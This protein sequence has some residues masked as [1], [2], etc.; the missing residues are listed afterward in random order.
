MKIGILIFVRMDSKRLPKKA[1][2]L[3]GGK[4]LISHVLEKELELLGKNLFFSNLKR[5]VMTL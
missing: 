1:F 2:K 5:K 3:I 4:K